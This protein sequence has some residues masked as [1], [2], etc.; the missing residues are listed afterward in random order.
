MKKLLTIALSILFLIAAVGLARAEGPKA[1]G[2]KKDPPAKTAGVKKPMAK[3]STA[4]GEITALDTATRTLTVK[5]KK[6][7]V[8][9]ITDDKTMVKE[10]KEKKDFTAPKT[11]QKVTVKYAVDKEKNVARSITIQTAKPKAAATK[12]PK[13]SGTTGKTKAPTK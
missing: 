2:E 10:G 1:G 11:G 12:P 5:G 7:D 6:N 13:T 9:L 3:T 4:R 8:T